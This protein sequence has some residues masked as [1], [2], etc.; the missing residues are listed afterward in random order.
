MY[1]ADLLPTCR[2]SGRTRRP[3]ACPLAHA[4]SGTHPNPLRCPPL[5]AHRS[6]SR[7][8]CHRTTRY[9]LSATPAAA[10]VTNRNPNP[11]PNT[12]PLAAACP[13]RRL[14]VGLGLQPVDFARHPQVRAPTPNPNPRPSPSPKLNP[15][16]RPTPTPT[17]APTLIPALTQSFSSACS[18][19]WTVVLLVYSQY[20]PPKPNPNRTPPGTCSTR[21]TS[22]SSCRSTLALV[23]RA[24][25]PAPSTR[26]G[27]RAR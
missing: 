18:T 14:Q 9:S 3:L 24:S 6:I 5:P 19:S 25:S 21:W 26:R 13:Q 7:A 20:C 10:R 4:I 22:S 15:S 8:W 27:R 11:N 1:T 16:P 17:R 23:G 12:G 2:Q